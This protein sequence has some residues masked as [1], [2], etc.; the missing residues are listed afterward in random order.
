MHK[1]CIVLF[2]LVC[3][4]SLSAQENS[5]FIEHSQIPPAPVVSSLTANIEELSVTLSW[6]HAPV[7]S[8][9]YEIFRSEN[10]I[11]ASSFA[12]TT[13]I[14]SVDAQT[15][16]YSETIEKGKTFY[17]AVLARAPDYSLYEF[18]IPSTNS[19][20]VGITSGDTIVEPAPVEFQSFDIMVRNDAVILAWSA[21]SRDKN[22]ILYRSTTTFTNIN[23][24]AQ[25]IVL[26][27]FIDTGTPFVDYPVPGVPYYYAIV[28]ENAVRSGTVS[29]APDKNTNRVPV[30]VSPLFSRIQKSKL[31]SL[32]PMPLPWLNPSHQVSSDRFTFSRR[33]ESIILQ[34]ASLAKSTPSMIR[35]SVIL[36]DD[37]AS[38]AGGEEYALRQIISKNIPSNNWIQAENELFDFLS[39]RRTPKTTARTRFYLGQ[40]YY[41]QGK[42]NKALLEFLLA[43]DYYY[44]QSQEWIQYVL[45]AL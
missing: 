13:K 20:L 45:A 11:T 40:A 8:L 10:P 42:H 25:A 14:G 41:F 6:V 7:E 31:P 1:N 44:S 17:Y 26:S 39:L 43:Q 16:Q 30:E 4:V 15:T 3:A 19:L 37:A 12:S 28:D 18:F 29:F 33:T 27:T 23:S 36:D 22:L 38:T 34:L 5:A 9:G 32:R 21:N 2:S 35:R 24:L